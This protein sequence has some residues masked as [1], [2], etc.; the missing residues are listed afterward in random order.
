MKPRS[1][2]V[3]AAALTLVVALLIGLARRSERE[4]VAPPI[5]PAR[6]PLA[7]AAPRH[8]G[9]APESPLDSRAARLH[10]IAAQDDPS[11]RAQL[12]DAFVDALGENDRAAGLAELAPFG[13]TPFMDE[14]R[15]RIVRQWSIADPRLAA[16]WVTAL[17]ADSSR[18]ALLE[19]VAL[20]WS[21]SDPAAALAWVQQLPERSARERIVGLLGLELAR[22]DP[23]AALRLAADMESGVPRDE[24]C[25]HAA[26]QW[27]VS[28]PRAA[29]A[30]ANEITDGRLRDNV[31]IAVVN[32]WAFTDPEA[33]AQ[34]VAKDLEPGPGQAR[35]V[36][37]VAQRRTQ[38]DAAA[39]AAW[40]AA[41][42]DGA[43][44]T[45]AP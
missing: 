41:H 6:T 36:A 5:A 24:L 13:T 28:E 42:P 15:R 3:A 17:P 25:R 11:Q 37:L 44:P 19:Q 14:I 26:S 29:V 10:E 18:G 38:H 23:L 2:S 9:A 35:L 4:V 20:G 45:S 33:A 7:A 16:A 34:F 27:A 12:I 8:E 39:E 43:G 21:G 32:V 1:L 22:T 30:W 40:V 31:L